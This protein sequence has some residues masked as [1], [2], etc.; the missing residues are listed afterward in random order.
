VKRIAVTMLGF[1][2][3]LFLTWFT[4]YILSR[5]DWQHGSSSVSS[6][7]DMEHCSSRLMTLSSLAA[8]FFVPA[9]AFASLN[10]IAYGR[11]SVTRWL[12]FFSAGSFLI[13]LFY[14]AG[15]ARA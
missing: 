11:W 14:L 6:C 4:L 1:G 3:G 12:A 5:V 7:A 13:F 15:Y 2:W 10:A 9:V 8:V